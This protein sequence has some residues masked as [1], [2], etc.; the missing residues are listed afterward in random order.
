MDHAD[1]WKSGKSFCVFG[2]VGVDQVP[3]VSELKHLRTLRAHRVPRRIHRL[4]RRPRLKIIRCSQSYCPTTAFETVR[5]A[6]RNQHPVFLLVLVPE[7]V[8]IAEIYVL[9]DRGIG[10]YKRVVWALGKAD[11]VIADRNAYRLWILL[12]RVVAGI[13]EVV[14]AA[15][16]DHAAGPA[17]AGVV[18][19]GAGCKSNRQFLPV[20]QIAR[21]RM[22]L[23]RFAPVRVLDAQRVRRA[24]QVIK[25]VNP[26]VN[27]GYRISGSG[28][29]RRTT[30]D[31]RQ[32]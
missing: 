20:H 19:G 26:I 30:I 15:A 9:I 32:C 29:V 12:V 27:K 21:Y 28:S 14:R 8:G 18:G 17:P 24:A 16:F 22:A 31:L 25:V 7:D 2:E 11:S 1:S 6:S 5:M 10:R 13:E 4:R 3:P 23:G